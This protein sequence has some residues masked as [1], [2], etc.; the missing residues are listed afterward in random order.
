[1]CVVR[2]GDHIVTPPPSSESEGLGGP[3][4]T[5]IN[6]NKVSMK[7]LKMASKA[8]QVKF[9]QSQNL[10]E[11]NGVPLWVANGTRQVIPVQVKTKNKKDS[12]FSQVDGVEDKFIHAGGE[13]EALLEHDYDEGPDLYVAKVETRVPADIDEDEALESL[14]GLPAEN[15]AKAMKNWKTAIEG[16]K[17]RMYIVSINLIDEDEEEDD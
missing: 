5:N 2:N 13:Y 8:K 4:Y 10:V 6:I 14:S 7:T 15:I 9:L 17:T 16:E 12:F 3:L 11:F 1:M